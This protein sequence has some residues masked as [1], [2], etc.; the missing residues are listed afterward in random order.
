METVMWRNC[1][2]DCVVYIQAA[3]KASR[4][5]LVFIKRIAIES[6]CIW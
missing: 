1:L 3:R 6:H 5:L 4:R 2:I